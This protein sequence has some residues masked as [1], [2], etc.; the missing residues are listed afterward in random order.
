MLQK[1]KDELDYVIAFPGGSG[2]KNMIDIA[3]KELGKE[4]VI[5]V[6]ISTNRKIHD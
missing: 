4:K 5:I 1:E 6:E 3:V 2:T